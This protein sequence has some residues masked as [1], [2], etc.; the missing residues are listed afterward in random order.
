MEWLETME[1]HRSGTSIAEI[2]RRTDRD[3]KTGRKYVLAKTTEKYYCRKTNDSAIQ[4]A[5]RVYAR[6]ALQEVVTEPGSKISVPEKFSRLT[7]YC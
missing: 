2:A 6:P 7:G 1:M 5:Q 3:R 4:E